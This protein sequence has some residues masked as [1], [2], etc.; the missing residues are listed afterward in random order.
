MVQKQRTSCRRANVSSDD[1]ANVHP[2][3]VRDVRQRSLGGSH[4]CTDALGASD[5]GPERRRLRADVKYGCNQIKGIQ[6][7]IWPVIRETGPRDPREMQ[8]VLPIRSITGIKR[9]NVLSP[10]AM[11]PPS[12]FQKLVEEYF[13]SIAK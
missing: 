6:V 5:L 3:D 13:R 11:N 7:E 8:L 1:R 12:A 9:I 10:R 4:I 2:P